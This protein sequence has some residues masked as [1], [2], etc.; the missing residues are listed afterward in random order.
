MRR[1]LCP[2][3]IT[4]SIKQYH[5]NHRKHEHH[6]FSI[7]M[8]NST[9]HNAHK[10]GNSYNKRFSPPRLQH[11]NY[12]DFCQQSSNHYTPRNA[13]GMITVIIILQ[14]EESIYIITNAGYP[15]CRKAIIIRP[16]SKQK[17]QC[18]TY[19]GYKIFYFHNYY[20]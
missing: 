14:Q 7:T 18:R 13:Y 9:Q 6:T 10:G 19:N 2:S 5:D 20:S 17:Q 8:V 4:Q 11:H 16:A 3:V 12:G 1:K 15:Q